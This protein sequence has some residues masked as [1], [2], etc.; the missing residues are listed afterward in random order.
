MVII[1]V[2][3][4]IAVGAA[5]VGVSEIEEWASEAFPPYI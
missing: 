4:K 5:N 2:K 3:G 1:F